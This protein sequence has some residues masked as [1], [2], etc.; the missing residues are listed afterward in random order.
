MKVN[1]LSGFG[2][3][4]FL[5]YGSRARAWQPCLRAMCKSQPRTPATMI[6]GE[7]VRI[8]L[9]YTLSGE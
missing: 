9:P 1:P 4:V 2:G 3:L 8:H 6:A 5:G 7:E